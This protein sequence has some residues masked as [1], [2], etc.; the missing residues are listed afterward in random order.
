MDMNERTFALKGSCRA[1]L[2]FSGGMVEFYDRRTTRDCVTGYAFPPQS[3]GEMPAEMM[4]AC[5]LM[6]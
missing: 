6:E 4:Q 3:A 1:V 2:G 5:L